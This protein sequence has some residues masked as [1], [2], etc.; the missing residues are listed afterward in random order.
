MAMLRLSEQSNPQ[1]DNTA[2]YMAVRTRFFDDLVL[3]STRDGIRQVVILATGMDTRAFRLD[4]PA[5]TDWYELD[6]SEVLELK[7]EILN[8]EN[9]IP[10]CRRIV[11]PVDLKQG[12]RSEVARAGLGLTKPS[13]W[14]VEGL[15]YYLDQQE[16]A[17]LLGQISSCAAAGSVLGADLVSA[18]FF[19]SPWTK[20]A[21]EMM[22][23]RG[24]AWRFG[25][26]DP[27][28]LFT[29][30]GWHAQVTQPGEEGANYGRWS[31]PVP[32]RT[33]RELPHSFLVKATRT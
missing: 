31:F 21:L 1:R 18:S 23:A 4:L 28:L 3:Q 19:E 9:A 16:V 7:E 29:E 30:H 25:T 2:S 27:E 24:L 26:D 33:Q 6:Q 20:K 22:A 14:I 17:E 13:M 10:R 12:W 32:L 8:S 11:L 5:E 15:L